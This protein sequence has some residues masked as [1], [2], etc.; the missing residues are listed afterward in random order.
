[1]RRERTDLQR[2]VH[3]G[4]RRAGVAVLRCG[5]W[6]R[7]RA[8]RRDCGVAGGAGR[9]RAGPVRDLRQQDA[10]IDEPVDGVVAAVAARAQAVRRVWVLRLLSGAAGRGPRGRRV[11]RTLAA[12][13][14]SATVFVDPEP[15]NG[16]AGALA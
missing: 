13:E 14:V 16:R 2:R 5:H 6:L 7:V 11:A 4:G 3:A 8:G 12:R 15:E 1:R 9:A 10:A